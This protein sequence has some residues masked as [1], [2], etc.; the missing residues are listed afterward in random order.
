MCGDLICLG[1][2]DLEKKGLR[3]HFR[4]T[5][6]GGYSKVEIALFF[7]VT[8]NRMRGNGLKLL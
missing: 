8:S 5:S 2:F 1:L 4:T 7:P 6:K 3:G